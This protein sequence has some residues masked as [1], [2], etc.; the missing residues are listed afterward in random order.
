MWVFDPN[1][2]QVNSA[3]SRATVNPA[4]NAIAIP[5]AIKSQIFLHYGPAGYYQFCSATTY[6]PPNS[7]SRR[8]CQ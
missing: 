3:A 7:A 8:I 6:F 1:Y 5:E 2:D 4:A